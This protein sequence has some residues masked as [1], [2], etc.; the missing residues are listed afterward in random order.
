MTSLRYS[1]VRMELEPKGVAI[2]SVRG[3]HRFGIYLAAILVVLLNLLI[4]VM[5]ATYEELSEVSTIE[6]HYARAQ[7]VLQYKDHKCWPAPLNVRLSIGSNRGIGPLTSQSPRASPSHPP[8]LAY[9]PALLSST[10]LLRYSL[11]DCL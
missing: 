1:D 9:P 8:T 11:R 10:A 2:T 3:M 4:A 5:S 7:I 6:W